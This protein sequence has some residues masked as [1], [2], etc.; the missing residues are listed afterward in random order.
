M[1]ESYYNSKGGVGIYHGDTAIPQV[2]FKAII[3]VDRD[4]N[5]ATLRKH[6]DIN[7]ERELLEVVKAA[8]IEPVVVI[9]PHKFGL[10]FQ[11]QVDLVNYLID[12]SVNRRTLALAKAMIDEDLAQA[13]EEVKGI[14]SF[15]SNE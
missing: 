1:N 14:L 4:E 6:G 10:N 12:F 13:E 5:I 9:Y 8:L 3:T 15:I 11:E 7:D 2:N